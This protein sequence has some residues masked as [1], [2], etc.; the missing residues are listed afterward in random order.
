MPVIALVDYSKAVLV[1]LPACLQHHL[2]S[3]LNVEAQL[4]IASDSTTTSMMHSSHF[5]GCNF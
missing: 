3:V 5:S 1:D 2:E 4:I